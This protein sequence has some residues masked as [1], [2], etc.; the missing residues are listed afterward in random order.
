MLAY[1]VSCDLEDVHCFQSMRSGMFNRLVCAIASL[2][3]TTTQHNLHKQSTTT[4]VFKLY[5]L[6]QE[7][8]AHGI[9]G[10]LLLRGWFWGFHLTGVTSCT[11][12]G[13]IWHGWDPRYFTT[14]GAA[15]GCDTPK[16]TILTILE[17][18][19]PIGAYPLYNLTKFLQFVEGITVG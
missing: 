17:Y 7:G 3:Q 2:K 9:L 11:N 1:S 19:R 18:K 10:Y 5:I 14:I 8:C 16:M 4:N 6:L 13:E 12:Q 15:V